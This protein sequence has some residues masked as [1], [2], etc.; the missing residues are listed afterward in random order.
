M[1]GSSFQRKQSAGSNCWFSVTGE[2]VARDWSGDCLTSNPGSSVFIT[3]FSWFWCWMRQHEFREGTQ[4]LESWDGLST[5]SSISHFASLVALGRGPPFSYLWNEVRSGFLGL[6]RCYRKHPR[7][8]QM[9]R[10]FTGNG[11]FTIVSCYCT[12]LLMT[13]SVWRVRPVRGKHFI[14]GNLTC[15]LVFGDCF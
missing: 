15:F 8:F 1:K 3:L 9:Q 11:S 6:R 7:K 5:F 12:Q 10:S 4:S 13:I 14:K 2:S